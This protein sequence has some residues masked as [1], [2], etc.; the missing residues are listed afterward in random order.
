M[1]NPFLK[2]AGISGAKPPTPAQR[3]KA[4]TKQVRTPSVVP[5]NPFTQSLLPPVTPRR[6]TQYTP[7]TTPTPDFDFYR[8]AYGAETMAE[9]RQ[10][11][12]QE[13]KARRSDPSSLENVMRRVDKRLGTK[14]GDEVRETVKSY[15]WLRSGGLNRG[16]METYVDEAL[17][18]IEN[19]GIGAVQKAVA[20]GRA[21]R[22]DV[23]MQPAPDADEVFAGPQRNLNNAYRSQDELNF[24]EQNGG[25]L[26]DQRAVL[27]EGA[28]AAPSGFGDQ[29]AGAAYNALNPIGGL[30]AAGSAIG[31][32][33]AGRPVRMS[34]AENIGNRM[35][36][37]NPN[38][39]NP[40]G[41][42]GQ[43]LG[44]M[45]QPFT[46]G[47]RA[48]VSATADA[49]PEA[50]VAL[51]AGDFVA[52]LI[53]SF[54]TT[55]GAG[56]MTQLQRWANSGARFAALD[57]PG[58][59]QMLS[60]A[61]GDVGKASGAFLDATVGQL[62][63]MGKL[64][65]PKV[66]IAEKGNIAMGGLQSGLFILAGLS[67]GRAI[68]NP[69]LK[70]LVAQNQKGRGDAK[71]I[72]ETAKFYIEQGVP[73]QEAIPM[74]RAAANI[75]ADM[76]AAAK[77]IEANPDAVPPVA[78][79][80]DFGTDNA[81]TRLTDQLPEGLQG[82]GSEPAVPEPAMVRQSP[83][84][85][86]TAD[87]PPVAPKSLTPDDVPD[88]FDA[89][90][91]KPKQ[92]AP[93][94]AKAPTTKEPSPETAGVSSVEPAPIDVDLPDTAPLQSVVDGAAPRTTPPPGEPLDIDVFHGTR[95]KSG[96]QDITALSG[97]KSRGGGR[98]IFFGATEGRAAEYGTVLKGRLKLNAPFITDN[99]AYVDQ[100]RMI[101]AAKRGFHYN[102]SGKN[103][104]ASKELFWSQYDG[105][106]VLRD[107]NKPATK[108][109]ILEIIVP[110][111]RGVTSAA[112]PDPVPAKEPWEM[113]KKE[114]TASIVE[115][116]KRRGE[117]KTTP[118]GKQL[119]RSSR[120]SAGS[121]IG[122]VIGEKG[123]H[124]DH[125]RRAMDEGKPVP[126]DV[127][128]D[129]PVKAGSGNLKNPW[130][131]TR[132]EYAASGRVTDRAGT[133]VRIEDDFMG[134]KALDWFR[135]SD[136]KQ[137]LSDGKPV[138]PEVLADYP[139]LQ[140]KP[141]PEAVKTPEDSPVA[142]VVGQVLKN[143]TTGNL[144]RILGS[145][146]SEVQLI[147]VNEKGVQTGNGNYLSIPRKDWAEKSKNWEPNAKPEVKEPITRAKVLAMDLDDPRLDPFDDSPEIEAFQ[148]KAAEAAG[149]KNIDEL[150]TRIED[151]Q[152]Q[153][154]RRKFEVEMEADAAQAKIGDA[155]L[156]GKAAS[157]G[158]N[159]IALKRHPIHRNWVK[160]NGKRTGFVE[161]SEETVNGQIGIIE[162]LYDL[163]RQMD[164]EH[165]YATPAS[166]N[167][168]YFKKGTFMQGGLT[169]SP[170]GALTMTEMFTQNSHL[171]DLGDN[172]TVGTVGGARFMVHQSVLK[173]YVSQ[174][175]NK[176]KYATDEAIERVA[177]QEGLDYEELKQAL[178][179]G[180]KST[181]GRPSAVDPG[182]KK[183]SSRAKQGQTTPTRKA[184]AKATLDAAVEEFK[185]ESGKLGARWT[186]E[187][188]AA[189]VKAAL[190]VARSAADYGW[191]SVEDMVQ[192]FAKAVGRKLSQQ[193][194][195][196]VRKAWVEAQGEKAPASPA[197]ATK[198]APRPA[199]EDA[200]GLANRFTNLEAIAR[201]EALGGTYH[202]T[203]EELAAIGKA[204]YEDGKAEIELRQVLDNKNKRQ[205]TREGVATMTYYKRV[206]S[207]QANDLYKRIDS[208]SEEDA[209]NASMTLQDID[210]QL[211]RVNE[212]ASQA[213]TVFS[214]LGHALQIAYKPRFTF[215]D[216]KG[217]MTAANYGQPVPEKYLAMLKEVT[218]KYDR[219]EAEL[220]A[221]KES[222]AIMKEIRPKSSEGSAKP[223]KDA[224]E[225]AKKMRGSAL[226]QLRKLGLV[227]DGGVAATGGMGSKQAGAVR[228]DV[229][230][231]D[232][233][234]QRAIRSLARS[235]ILDGS[236]DSLDGILAKLADDLSIDGKPSLT[237]DQMLMY[238]STTFRKSMDDMQVQ[239][240]IANR[241]VRELQ[242][243]AEFRMKDKW[244]KA[245]A[246]IADVF[247]A[248]ARSL[249]SGLD[250]SAPFIQGLPAITTKQ[251]WQ[252]WKPMF[253]AMRHGQKA[254]DEQMARMQ[255]DPDYAAAVQAKLSTTE[256]DTG[257]ARSEE[258]FRGEIVKR[259][260]ESNI[261]V[262]KQIGLIL[263]QSERMYIAF[264]NDLRFKL[265]KAQ[266]ALDPT[267]KEYLDDVAMRIN[268][269]T[270]R[271]H[272]KTA[273]WLGNPAAGAAIYAPRYTYSGWQL[274]TGAPILSAKTKLGRQQAAKDYAKL[275]GMMS[276]VA[277]LGWLGGAEFDRDP[278][279]T[280]YGAIIFKNGRKVNLFGKMLQP[281]R[282]L[283]QLG[284][285]KIGMKGTYKEASGYEGASIIGQYFTGK[286]SPAARLGLQSLTGFSKYN[287]ATEKWEPMN[288]G[289]VAM[290]TLSPMSVRGVLD[291]A[292]AEGLLPPK[293]LQYVSDQAQAGNLLSPI[294]F[295]G[296]NVGKL[297][298]GARA[299]RRKTPQMPI[300][301]AGLLQFAPQLK[302]LQYP[303]GSPP[304][305]AELA[306][307]MRR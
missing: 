190:K 10:L 222:G 94:P 290:N 265:F 11:M 291:Q 193:E 14:Q 108:D 203:T 45:T 82:R 175:R 306:D 38:A 120:A 87:T 91:P 6:I 294:G 231:D 137:A 270:G 62:P 221:L 298:K 77:F 229:A 287:E 176:A 251:W 171:S 104:T 194:E 68:S 185:S 48:N 250:V 56:T 12:A 161:V 206:L 295:T 31:D 245:K 297:P 189:K 215:V 205:P 192:A 253:A 81:Q 74:A 35:I 163:T 304:S 125:V 44:D 119:S 29:L 143:K 118:E 54:A 147:P 273:E 109:N 164:N 212:Y 225:V 90:N 59:A 123:R 157:G 267:N 121:F 244:G 61:G 1:E 60:Q 93:P 24:V 170:P 58:Y 263:R 3:Q 96:V 166:V 69:E 255:N 184:T 127:L 303:K 248:T 151:F 78:D 57:A 178:Q 103:G 117:A 129:Y 269:M 84:D 235:Y 289:E 276:S 40:L 66:S 186:P 25:L 283:A 76:D 227:R 293:S 167:P 152:E 134:M 268:I 165:I 131:M 34:G 20:E 106:V 112:K 135:R 19:E 172:G 153:Y 89:P 275:I 73:K 169:K 67:S 111:T 126:A 16:G 8:V 49:S 254:V 9:R 211:A 259:M 105:I 86:P 23:R 226:S 242:A 286:F 188:E 198:P 100:A 155:N 220:K 197:K 141:K 122:Q 114:Y 236:A 196:A 95:A 154:S 284:W 33:A 240:N 182:T 228:W 79:A 140:P 43:E 158:G 75:R 88:F 115:E 301:P 71:L 174:L 145:D 159:H 156:S 249:Q 280:D 27:Q 305:L 168:L 39:G 214:G 261:P 162:E 292:G 271:G 41:F 53:P 233:T 22:D 72:Q 47:Y 148:A 180:D 99:T 288:G 256:M 183:P 150:R 130:E 64:F 216:L 15:A 101:L 239:R 21:Y 296:A 282:L 191:A 110:D 18:R 136:I 4:L 223:P 42:I 187:Q 63:N 209:L 300:L 243:D 149:V 102:Q 200:T 213:K 252:A 219:A 238:L 92:K 173:R 17:E 277:L 107:K 307:K 139:D 65:D 266:K 181:A 97:D 234:T 36:Q 299:A 160:V 13:A 272:G 285:G 132:Q 26:Q 80:P 2:A 258:T 207:D 210:I 208:M 195:R 28:N 281:I 113:T 128:A 124:Q 232:V 116:A 32:L 237:S 201:G 202:K 217:M 257:F 224:A 218:G 5:Q 133:K 274:A 142:V 7:E 199:G 246:H 98:Q 230:P 138:P 51:M 85:A 279:S 50:Q 247:Q 46:R 146:D 264:M 177:K 302:G 70:R 241:A 179:M 262:L 204:L 55:G 260:E 52:Q 278:R 37:D 144:Y 30:M 83:Q